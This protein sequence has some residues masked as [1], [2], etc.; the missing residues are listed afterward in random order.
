MVEIMQALG[1]IEGNQ[2]QQGQELKQQ[3]QQLKQQGQQLKQLTDKIETMNH[4]TP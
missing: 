2:M 1:R 3:G 4:P